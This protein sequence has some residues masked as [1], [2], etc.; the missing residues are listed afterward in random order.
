MRLGWWTVQVAVVAV[1]WVEVA[2]ESARL[3]GWAAMTCSARVDVCEWMLEEL[4][5]EAAVATV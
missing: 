1:G 2:A 5:V 3:C 4:V